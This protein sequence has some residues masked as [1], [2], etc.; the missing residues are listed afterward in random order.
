MKN[1]IKEFLNRYEFQQVEN[2]NNNDS[3]LLLFQYNEDGYKWQIEIYIKDDA[4]KSIEFI[5]DDCVNQPLIYPYNFDEF[6]A[7]V[8]D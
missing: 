6:C 3:N 5:E 8:D 4:I 1:K 2:K 7:I